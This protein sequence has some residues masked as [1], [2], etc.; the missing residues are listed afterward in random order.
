MCCTAVQSSTVGRNRVYV[1]RLQV[2]QVRFRYHV[3]EIHLHMYVHI[4]FKY[5]PFRG[6]I[7]SRNDYI[8]STSSNKNR[9]PKLRVL[10]RF[11][12]PVI[13]NHIKNVPLSR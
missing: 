13:I 10:F 5:N 12:F 8:S 2:L 9:Y 7:I 6:H 11:I 4:I 3:E 1:L